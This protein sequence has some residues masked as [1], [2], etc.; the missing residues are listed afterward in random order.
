MPSGADDRYFYGHEGHRLGQLGSQLDLHDAGEIGL[1]DEWL[2]LGVNLS[3]SRPSR[4]WTFPI[5]AVSQSEGGFELVHQSVAV[6][7]N[8]HITGDAAGR[9][10]VAMR[11]AVDTS[12]AESRRPQHVHRPHIDQ[13]HSAPITA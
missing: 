7:P 2:G 11:L 12:L 9:W 6:L 5:E 4:V 13:L 3:F 1:V 8:W 10:S